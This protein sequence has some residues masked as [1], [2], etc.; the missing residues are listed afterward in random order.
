MY[1]L[2]RT[3]GKLFTKAVIALIW[4]LSLGFALPMGLVHTFGHVPD[5]DGTKPFCYIDFGSN[6]TNSTFA[7]FKA[8]RSVCQVSE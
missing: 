4:L 3:P 7:V 6:A 1:P 5:G 8:Y 2:R